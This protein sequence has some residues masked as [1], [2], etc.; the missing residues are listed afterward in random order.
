MHSD[1]VYLHI[2]KMA[3]KLFIHDEGQYNAPPCSYLR[4]FEHAAHSGMLFLQVTTCMLT[5]PSPISSSLFAPFTTLLRTHSIRLVTPQHKI[6]K[7]KDL[8]CFI[9]FIFLVLSTMPYIEQ[10]LIT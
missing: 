10:D 6:H 5:L 1:G 8:V 2:H 7:G 9:H 3:N 4:I